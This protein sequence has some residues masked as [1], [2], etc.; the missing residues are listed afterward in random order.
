MG[1]FTRRQ[2]TDLL[3]KNLTAIE[4]KVREFKQ[5][6]NYIKFV[7][8]VACNI[9]PEECEGR[10]NKVVKRTKKKQ[11]QKMKAGGYFYI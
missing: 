3:T 8:T 4:E 6:K 2:F 9:R 7:Y 5:M 10:V 1:L 11:Q